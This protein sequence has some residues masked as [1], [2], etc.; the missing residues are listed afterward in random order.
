MTNI[1]RVV[2][3]SVMVVPLMSGLG[4]AARTSTS[5]SDYN[6]VW[7]APS[8]NEHGSMTGARLYDWKFI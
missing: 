4:F 5:V 1:L 2:A 8:E 7:L 6:V 3:A